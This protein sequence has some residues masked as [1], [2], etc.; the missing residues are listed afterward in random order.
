MSNELTDE[1]ACSEMRNLIARQYTVASVVL[2]WLTVL[3]MIGMTAYVLWSWCA[4]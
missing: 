3:G 1:Q 2:G 4:G